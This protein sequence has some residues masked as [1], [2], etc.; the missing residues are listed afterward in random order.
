ME[1]HF[2]EQLLAIMGVSL[3][4]TVLLRRLNLPNIIAY[5]IAGCLIGPHVL[6]WIANPAEFSFLAEFGVVFLLF[7]LGLEF[8]LPK[9]IALR[10]SVFGLG[11]VQVIFCTLIYGGATWLWGASIEA[12]IIIAGALTLSSTAIVTKE[13][14]ALNQV[15]SRHGQLSIGVL[16]F[17][18]LAAVLFLILVPVLAGGE[19]NSLWSSLGWAL[20]KGVLL[21]ILLLSVGKWLLPLLYK[22]VARAKSEE[23]FVLSTLVIV[24]LAAWV[25][26]SFQ[27]S[28]ALGGFVI[29]MMLGESHYRHQIESDIRTIK[30]ILLGLFFVT[31]GMSVQVELLLEFWPRILLFTAGLILTK[32]LLISFMVKLSGDNKHNSLQ[33]GLNLAQ[34]GEFGLALLALAV[35]HKVVPEEQASF[36]ILVAIFSMAASPFLIR[37][38]DR[39]SN[40]L[41][42]LLGGSGD[43]EEDHEANLPNHDH[44]IIGGFGRVGHTL[45]N[46]LQAN[47]IDYIAIDQDVERVSRESPEGF[48]V[49]YGDCTN[50]EILQRC[51][52][53][54]ARMAILTFHSIEIAKKS[55]AHIRAVDLDLPIIVRC[56]ENGDFSELIELGANQVIPEMLEASLVIGEQV[57]LQLGVNKLEILEQ[58]EQER[59][60]QLSYKK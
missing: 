59:A 17:Q 15:H 44:V 24:M 2:F 26:H 54:S 51:H 36:I 57:L 38:K 56:S 58:I 8:S 12:A 11:G 49:V 5:L 28:M 30:D 20:F 53:N 39:V 18:D 4:A 23:V 43:K 29:G 40:T 22:E 52:I 37:H 31:I 55:V 48:N 16:L 10:A 7:S 45:A 1:E 34:A 27:L 47:N 14:S 42:N 3:A 32:A 60:E 19:G 6:G 9:L 21:I 13:L 41:W 50:I 35:M 25:T 33:T 46:L